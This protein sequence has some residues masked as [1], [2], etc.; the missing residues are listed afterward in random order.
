MINFVV[1]TRSRATQA[2]VGE[3]IGLRNLFWALTDAM[4]HNP[5]P[6]VGGHVLP[7]AS[8]GVAYRMFMGEAY[9]QVRNI[10]EKVVTSGLIY[11]PSSA[12]D[13]RNPEIAK[14]LEKYVRGSN[15][16]DYKERIKTMKLLWDAIG[17]EFVS[18]PRTT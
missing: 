10:I 15:G 12:K 9:T 13:L 2:L 1:P 14:Y 8:A 16:I 7:N 6:W 3:V 11:L 18:A 5:E 4:A 17:T